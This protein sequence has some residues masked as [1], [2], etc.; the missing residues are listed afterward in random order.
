MRIKRQ[1]SRNPAYPAKVQ[2]GLAENLEGRVCRA[3]AT[4]RR[5][6]FA[7]IM[8][9]IA[10]ITLSALVASLTRSVSTDM[11]LARNSDYDAEM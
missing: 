11:R 4:R 9:M 2:P 8:V 5:G 6:G 7:L 3:E 1:Q 10:I